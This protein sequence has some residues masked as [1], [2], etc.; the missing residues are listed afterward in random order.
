MNGDLNARPAP[1]TSPPPLARPLLDQLRQAARQR[2]Q[3]EAVATAIADCC[4]RF[5]LFHGKR[6][7]RD[8]GAAEVE[9]FLTHLECPR[10]MALTLALTGYVPLHAP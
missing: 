1:P 3:P 7:P 4:R 9:Q 6:H 5:I 8:M 2:G 10:G